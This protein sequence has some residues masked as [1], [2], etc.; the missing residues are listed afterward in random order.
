MHDKSF[1]MILVWV[2]LCLYS[3]WIWSKTGCRWV[4]S[5]VF[6][7][8]FF[9]RCSQDKWVR[10]KGPD[11]FV[12]SEGMPVNILHKSSFWYTFWLSDLTFLINIQMLFMLVKMWYVSLH[13]STD[14]AMSSCRVHNKDFMYFVR[15]GQKDLLQVLLLEN[16]RLGLER[17]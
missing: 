8:T 9:P 1:F 14:F 11:T 12:E 6:K 15:T 13:G 16:F 17:T 5:S 10:N 4:V 7:N 3:R 2:L